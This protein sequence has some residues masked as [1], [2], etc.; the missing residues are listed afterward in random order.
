MAEPFETRILLLLDEKLGQEGT[1]VMDQLFCSRCMLENLVSCLGLDG[2]S[3]VKVSLV[4]L[5]KESLLG[6][7]K[8]HLTLFEVSGIGVQIICQLKLPALG[9]LPYLICAR[10]GRGARHAVF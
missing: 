5:R 3:L 6:G 10:R 8:K 4:A 7:C 2:H 1:G 9:T